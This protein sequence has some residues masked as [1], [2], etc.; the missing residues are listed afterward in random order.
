ME[1]GKVG[2]RYG[3]QDAI[4]MVRD[5]F[6][7]E[8][9]RRYSNNNILLQLTIENNIIQF[10]HLKDSFQ[11]NIIFLIVQWNIFRYNITTCFYRLMKFIGSEL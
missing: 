11:S 8:Y 3:Y 2:N 1:T 4:G 10:P 5:T 7:G 9:S 6:H